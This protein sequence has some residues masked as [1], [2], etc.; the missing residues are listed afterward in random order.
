MKKMISKMRESGLLVFLILFLCSV[1]GVA[2]ASVMTADVVNPEGGGAVDTGAAL[3]ATDTRDNSEHLL[4]DTIDD[5]VTKIRPYDVVLDSI[6][7]RVSDTKTSNNQ[8]IRH[9]AIDVI[10]LTAQLTTAVT[11]EP[12][13]AALATS[14]NGI[15]ACEQTIIVKGVKG[16]KEDGVTVDDENDLMLYVVGKDTSNQPL[17]IAVNG[18]GTGDARKIPDIAVGTKLIRAGRA[19]SELQIQTD[20]YSGVPTDWDQHLQKFMA[21]VEVSTLFERADKEVDW[22]FTDD[23]EEA[24]FDMKR[25]Q[26]VTFWLGIKRRIKVKNAHNK[27]AEDVYFTK[28]VWNQAGKDFSF[29]G[30]PVDINGLVRLMKHSFTGN[31][32]GKKKLLIC[33]SDVVEALETVE[34]NRIIREG[35][36]MVAY[37]IEVNSIISKFGTLLVVHDQ[38]LDDMGMSDKAFVLDADF[39]RKWTMGWRVNDFDFRKSGDSDADGRMLMEICGLVLKNPNAHSRVSLS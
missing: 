33:G 4:L 39:L 29:G 23:E 27:K 35:S 12:Q 26:N 17:V 18:K 11:G 7:R 1:F 38:S 9:Y 14:N 21:Q 34:Y 5:K 24:I 6:S 37:G 19:G 31:N 8:T 10:D 3:T 15:F 13:Q 30:L 16:Y 36:K 32:S 28:G 20:A 25:V 22:N 2:D